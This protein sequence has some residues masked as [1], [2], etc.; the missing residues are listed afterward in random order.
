MKDKRDECGCHRECHS[1][2]HWCEKPCQWPD[3]LTDAEHGE[4]LAEV[5]AY[6]EYDPDPRAVIGGHVAAIRPMDARERTD[7]RD[8]MDWIS[9]GAP[10]WRTDDPATH[11]QHLCVYAVPVDVVERTVLL[12]DHVKAGLWVPPGG[13]VEPGEILA[14]AAMRELVEE[15]GPKGLSSNPR[16]Q[17]LFLSVTRTRGP[18]SHTDVTLW[19]PVPRDSAAPIHLDRCEARGAR[20][21]DL[22]SPDA[23]DDLA[24]QMDPELGRFRAK[25]LA[26]LEVP[27]L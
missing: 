14:Q 4:L 9:K 19:F 5:A 16:R 7:R 6:E 21:L 2:P 15:I 18:D 3:C 12:I 11:A 20:W 27:Y 25:L 8:T 1:R 24:Q 17:P 13:H 10:L 23:W 26:D 22:D